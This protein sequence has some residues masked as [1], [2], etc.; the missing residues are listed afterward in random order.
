VQVAPASCS[1]LDTPS[2]L[3]YS[4]DDGVL[5]IVPQGRVSQS[6]RQTIHDMIRD[7]PNVPDPACVL[8]DARHA[9]DDT[10]ERVRELAQRMV[11]ELAPKTIRACAVL[12]A[13]GGQLEAH[14]F[15]DGAARVGLRVG[16]FSDEG[17]A[18]QWLSAYQC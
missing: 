13:R 10:P 15:R 2:V 4:V 14:A 17:L 7:N 8:V 1:I 16:I 6:E 11:A 3:S 5:I 18:R 9:P 12:V